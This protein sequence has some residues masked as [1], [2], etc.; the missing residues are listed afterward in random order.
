[1]KKGFDTFK[2]FILIS[3]SRFGRNGMEKVTEIYE[4]C[5][6]FTRSEG[7]YGCPQGKVWKNIIIDHYYYF[8]NL[9][10]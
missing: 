1:M 6:G 8:S 5:A 3:H 10:I 2:Y 4:C 7:D 9:I